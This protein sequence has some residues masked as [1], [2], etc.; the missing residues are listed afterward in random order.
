MITALTGS[1]GFLLKAE[2]D[3][4]VNSFVAEHGGLALEKLDGDEASYEQMQG[5]I[6]NRPFLSSKKLVVLRNPSTNKKFVERFETLIERVA[7]STDVV[8]VESK[9]DK[10]LAYYKLLK[11]LTDFHEF[12]ELDERELPVWLG[13]QAKAR[14][15]SLS[16]SDARYL[17]D[18]IGLNQQLLS[19]ELEKLLDFNPDITREAIDLLTEQTPQSTVFQLLDAAFAGNGKRAMSLYDEQRRQRVEPHAIM[20]MIAWQ[21]HVLAVIKTA[22]DKS[23]ND[24]AFEAKIS[25]YVLQKSQAITSKLSLKE[26]RALV[27]QV[28]DLDARMKSTSIDVGDAL[29]QLLIDIAHMI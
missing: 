29:R 20:G 22:G 25:P 13:S 14:G 12:S 16:S 3:R 6:E 18:R 2:L 28:A 8:I 5:S 21:L 19:K 23:P 7:D 17:I 27:R 1:N 4:L 11:K 24:I 15:G 26:L 9:L 10:R